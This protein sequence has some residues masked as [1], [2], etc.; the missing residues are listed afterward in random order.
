MNKISLIS[1]EKVILDATLYTASKSEQLA[2]ARKKGRLIFALIIILLGVLFVAV[3]KRIALLSIGVGAV[4]FFILPRYLS[5][6]YKRYFTKLVKSDEN[7]KRQGQS[8]D[9]YFNDTFIEI[10]TALLETKYSFENFEYI[11]ETSENIFI[12]LKLGEF[13]TFPKSQ[14]QDVDEIRN[15]FRRICDT[16]KIDYKEELDWQWK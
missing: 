11:A 1:D 8:F 16:R 13:L 10:K 15:Y 9:I 3:D 7:Q 2:S 6:Y 14:L 12:K 5:I 4:A